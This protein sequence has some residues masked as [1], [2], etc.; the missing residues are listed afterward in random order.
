[1][2]QQVVG[3]ADIRMEPLPAFKRNV[4]VEAHKRR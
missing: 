1:M 2:H 4:E 3:E